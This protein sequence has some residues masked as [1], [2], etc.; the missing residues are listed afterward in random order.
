MERE[1]TYVEDDEPHGYADIRV[2]DPLDEGHRKILIHIAEQ[3]GWPISAPLPD[4][5]ERFLPPARRGMVICNPSQYNM[6]QT[7]KKWATKAS[8]RHDRGKAHMMEELE[9]ESN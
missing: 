7:F 3:N 8:I 4:M 2:A 5:F 9:S 1:N 6:T